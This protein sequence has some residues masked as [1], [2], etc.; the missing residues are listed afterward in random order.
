MEF[1][2]RAG[3]YI[4][5]VVTWGRDANQDEGDGLTIDQDGDALGYGLRLSLR[6]VFNF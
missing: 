5:A 3:D 4:A 1:S 2:P 6:F